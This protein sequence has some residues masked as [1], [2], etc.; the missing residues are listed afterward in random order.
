MKQTK[1][2]FILYKNYYNMYSNFDE[3]TK[4][5][6]SL[7]II[8]F[9][10]EDKEPN[11]MPNSVQDKVWQKLKIYLIKEKETDMVKISSNYMDKIKLEN[12]DIR[13]TIVEWFSYKKEKRELYSRS[14]VLAIVD[15]VID[16]SNKYGINKV[17]EIVNLSIASDCKNI[18][19]NKIEDSIPISS[20]FKKPDENIIVSEE[21]LEECRRFIQQFKD[22][23]ER[24]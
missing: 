7:A 15:K 3:E 2:W 22:R 5:E 23:E 21:D 13:S 24:E 9:I 10:F 17:N 19:W 16:L 8:E 18:L 4:G 12:E 20:A 6:L 14:S 1:Q 11:F